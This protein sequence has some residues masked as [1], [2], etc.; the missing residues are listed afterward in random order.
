MVS[1]EARKM[2]DFD[3]TCGAARNYSMPKLLDAEAG[4]ISEV[5]Q[6]REIYRKFGGFSNLRRVHEV[7]VSLRNVQSE[8]RARRDVLGLP[9]GS[10]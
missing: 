8:I 2:L 4:L 1:L 6:R 7:V 3:I 10:R 5:N 9:G